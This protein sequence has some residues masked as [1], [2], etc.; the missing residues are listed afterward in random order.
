M[1]VLLPFPEFEN[2]GWPLKGC[3]GSCCIFAAGQ[4]GQHRVTKTYATHAE[5]A[6]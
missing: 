5:S 2:V 3:D 6:D 1:Q 4:G